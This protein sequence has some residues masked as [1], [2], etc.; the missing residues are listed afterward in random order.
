M[1]SG[2][3]S[4]SSH[5]DTESEGRVHLL[6]SGAGAG[7]HASV[8]WQVTDWIDVGFAYK[9][10]TALRLTGDADF[11]TPDSFA[12]RTQDQGAGADFMLPDKITFGALARFGDFTAV[13][14][15]G[16]TVWS[17]NDRLVIEFENDETDDSVKVSEWSPAVY[18]RAGGEYDPFEWLTVRLGTFFDQTPIPGRNLTPSSPDCN[19][20]G[21]TLGISGHFF[22]ILSIDAFYEFIAFIERESTSDTSPLASYSGTAHFVGL[23]LRLHLPL[24]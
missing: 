9:S 24:D 13:A 2:V 3:S 5:P 11:T 6:L 12:Y 7:G 4:T 19:R 21:L 16:V 10:R 18:F 23:G 14:D 15:L 22:D 20:T 17:V 1:T 8:F